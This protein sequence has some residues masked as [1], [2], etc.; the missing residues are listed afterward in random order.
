MPSPPSS[1]VISWKW[2]LLA[3]LLLAGVVLAL[4]LGPGA[5]PFVTP[6]GVTGP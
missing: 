4:L 6:E 5:Q 3:A 2:T 1:P